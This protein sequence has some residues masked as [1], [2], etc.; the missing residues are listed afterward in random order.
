[1]RCS[2]SFQHKIE[3]SHN[4]SHY[5]ESSQKLRQE[6]SIMLDKQRQDHEQKLSQLQNMLSEAN[7]QASINEHKFNQRNIELEKITPKYAE[8]KNEFTNIQKT[9]EQITFELTLLKD[10]H[11]AIR[12]EHHQQLR[13]ITILEENIRN[14]KESSSHVKHELEQANDKIEKLR[15][16]YQFLAQEKAKLEGFLQMQK[17]KSQNIKEPA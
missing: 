16:D 6:Q 9:N 15:S 4:L 3:K 1:M 8:L 7:K 12:V 13:T 17:T 11:K 10:D 14:E 5:Q 2:L